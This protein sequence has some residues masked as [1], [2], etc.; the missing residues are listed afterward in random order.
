VQ[1]RSSPISTTTIT[2]I[3]MATT[4]TSKCQTLPTATTLI[5]M[6]TPTLTPT[7]IN[8]IHT[9]IYSMF[10]TYATTMQDF[11]DGIH[12]TIQTIMLTVQVIIT[13]GF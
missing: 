1:T 5:R 9:I 3:L 8:S 6:L 10:N 12:Q 7:P 2:L 13:T 11:T 4:S